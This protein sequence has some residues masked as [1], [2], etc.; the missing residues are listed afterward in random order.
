MVGLTAAGGA[1]G[2]SPFSLASAISTWCTNAV[3]R[4]G[5]GQ[6][7]AVDEEGRGAVDVGVLGQLQ[8]GLHPRLELRAVQRRPE[9]GTSSAR[10]RACSSSAGRSSRSCPANSR[11]CISQNLPCSPAASAAS[12][13]SARRLVERQRQ[14]LPHQADLVGVGLL[15]LAQGGHHP[16]AERALELAVRDD[17]DGRLGVAA[18]RGIARSM[19]LRRAS[20]LS[21]GGSAR[22]GATPPARARPRGGGGRHRRARRARARPPAPA[23]AEGRWP[24]AR[25]PAPR[26]RRARWPRARR[27]CR[28]RP[29]TAPPPQSRRRSR[30][31]RPASS[32]RPDRAGA[33]S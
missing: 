15:Q 11:S 29:T 21:T 33:H 25:A 4:L 7:L 14:V 8:V 6:A 9:A 5:P 27:A 18:R 2:G 10:A 13:A 1:G 26:P 3:Q 32:H 19:A 16:G 23:P 24:G 28:C 20:A 17:G 12:A 22:P 30:P 31:H